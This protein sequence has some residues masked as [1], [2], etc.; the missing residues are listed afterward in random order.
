MKHGARSAGGQGRVVQQSPLSSLLHPDIMKLTCRHFL[1]YPSLP[2]CA[3][4]LDFGM[5]S[6]LIV[7]SYVMIWTTTVT[8]TSQ[9]QHLK[10]LR[11]CISHISAVMPS[12]IPTTAVSTVHQLEEDLPPFVPMSPIYLSVPPLLNSLICSVSSKDI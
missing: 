5:D 7:I 6:S 9:G 4:I 11:T 2:L 12:R 8:A 1:P 10:A 3:V